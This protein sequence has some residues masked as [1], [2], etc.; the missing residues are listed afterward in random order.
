MH[1]RHACRRAWPDARLGPQP[2][3][4]LG[5]LV[6]WHGG[7]GQDHD[8]VQFMRGA[9]SR[10]QAR[11]EFLL[12]SLSASMSRCETHRTFDRIPTCTV[13]TAIPM[14]PLASVGA[15]TGRAY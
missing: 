10:P 11:S 15:G 14:G 6:E 13:L 9:S 2:G 8:C 4:R 5:L 1:T 7:D 12:L 3:G